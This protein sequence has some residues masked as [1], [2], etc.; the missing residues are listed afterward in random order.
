MDRSTSAL[1][2]WQTK[3]ARGF[4]LFYRHPGVHVSNRSRIETRDGRLAL[5]VRGDGGYVI[6][7]GSVHV[8]GAVYELA[9]D[10]TVPRDQLPRFWPGWLTRPARPPALGPKVPRPTG[11]VV[12]R[13]RRYLTAIPRPEIGQGSDHA[14]LYAAARLA[15]GFGLSETEATQLIWEWAGGRVGWTYQW[16]VRK[17]R[18]AITYGTEPGGGAAMSA[19]A[20]AGADTVL[21]ESSCPTCHRENCEGHD[22]RDQSGGLTFVPASV[23]IAEPRPIAIVEGVAFADRVTVLV[24]VSGSGKTFLALDLSAHV[25]ADLPWHGRSIQC[26]SVAYVSFEGDA[27]GLRLRALREVAG[28]RLEHVYI[29]RGVEPLS[30][31]VDRD[32]LELSSRGELSV[33]AALEALTTD[34]AATNRPPI[35]L[36]VID[37]VR[38]SL[39]GSEDSSEAV[40]A[41][42]RSVRRLM[43]R[44]PG[45]AALLL[46]HAGWQDGDT[47]R[48]RERGSSAF[49]GNC[50]ATLYLEAEEYDAERGA[51]RLILSA[52]KVRDAERP[53]PFSLIR[54]R[55]DLNEMDT[56]GEPVTSCIIERDRRTREDREA[57]HQ[58]AVNAE[59][60]KVDQTV[61]KAMV[62]FPAAT[63]IARLRPYVGLRTGVVTDAVGRILRAGWA[64]EGPRGQPYTVTAAGRARQDEEELIS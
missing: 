41:Y 27:L 28:Q 38:A 16:V 12:Q 2:P 18:N 64:V 25:S 29:L 57:E 35:R 19:D 56:H 34:L 59:H 32:R 3:T 26:G 20:W 15:R 10:W 54:R 1:H 13:A 63:S 50:D 5:D 60:R 6:A 30:P 4:H 36:L 45:A 58:Q 17:V 49:R 48:K 52:L 40:S 47:T 22:A 21:D 7:P 31:I 53:A 9:G 37:T 51:A 23:V 33:A 61:L 55:V 11:D 39:S 44:V 43:T 24:S 8:T 46:H 62:D 14:T 42:L